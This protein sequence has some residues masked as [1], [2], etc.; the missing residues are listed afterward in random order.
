ML[1]NLLTL[2][3]AVVAA[4]AVLVGIVAVVSGGAD[5]AALT[6]LLGGLVLVAALVLV[7]RSTRASR[8]SHPEP[9][10]APPTP[11]MLA[12]WVLLGGLTTLAVVAA[13]AGNPATFVGP[14][15]VGARIVAEKRKSAVKR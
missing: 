10:L 2:L 4:A 9:R 8:P 3:G 5:P 14:A 6:T 11:R 1:P 7:R 13:R 12:M 15:F